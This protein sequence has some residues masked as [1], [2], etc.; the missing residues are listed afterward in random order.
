VFCY[1]EE[2]VI[3]GN[4]DC[5]KLQDDVRLKSTMYLIMQRCNEAL[6]WVPRMGY[7]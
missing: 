7:Q 3:C 6:P 5:R 1:E 2:L 4:E